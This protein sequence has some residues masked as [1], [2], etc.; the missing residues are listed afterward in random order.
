MFAPLLENGTL[1][2]VWRFNNEDKLWV[3]YDPRPIFAQFNTLRLVRPPVILIVRVN[4]AQLFRGDRLSVGWNYI[5][6]R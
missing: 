2:R 5:S 6:V 3:F 1:E 4:R